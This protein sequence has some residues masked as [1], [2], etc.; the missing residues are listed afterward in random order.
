VANAGDT[1]SIA[2]YIAFL[3]EGDQRFY[4]FGQPKA[5]G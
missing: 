5:A 3:R 2:K 4:T 1:E